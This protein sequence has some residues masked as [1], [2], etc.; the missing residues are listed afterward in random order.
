MEHD[1]VEIHDD[2][3]RRLVRG[4]SPFKMRAKAHIEETKEVMAQRH[5]HKMKKVAVKRAKQ[6]N[7]GW[8]SDKSPV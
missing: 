2:G 5:A 1:R 6:K 7:N 4:H 3:K 8:P